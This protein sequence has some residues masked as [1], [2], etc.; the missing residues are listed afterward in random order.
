MPI[1]IDV[2]NRGRIELPDGT[3]EA[4]IDSI[5]A[6]EF[7]PTGEDIAQ[8]L[9]EDPTFR[10]NDQQFAEFEKYSKTKQ[11]D[12]INGIASGIDSLV[13]TAATAASQGVQGAA[14]NPINYLEGIGQGTRQLYGFL[15]QSQDLG[16]ALFQFKDLVSGTGTLQSR[17]E[18]FNQ[19]RDFNEQSLKYESG[20]ETMLPKEMV[21]PEFAQGVALIA[22]PTMLVP[23][24]GQALG[25]EKLAARA[26]GRGAEIAGRGVQAAARPFVR[27]GQAAEG[28]VTQATGLT[29]EAIRSAAATSGVL[30]ATG[31]APAA[32]G[33]GALPT[34]ARTAVDVGTALE[35]A[36]SQ[37]GRA[38]TRIGALEAVGKIPEA[39][40]RQR[41][42]GT[43]G[44][45][46]GDAALNAA[47]VGTTGSIEG[48]TV[49]GVLGYLS[50]GEEG[51][52]AGIGSGAAS[53][54]LGSL[55]ARGLQKLTGQQARAA[56]KEDF[57]RYVAA[58][59]EKTAGL[60][61]DLEAR[62][63][64]DVA[65]SFMDATGVVRGVLGDV[66]VNL[67][68]SEDFRKKFGVGSR[69]VQISEAETPSVYINA[70]IYGKGRGDNPL[71]TLGHEMFHAFESSQQLADK[72]S[73]IKD[74]L[75]GSYVTKDG[76][77]TKVTNGMFDDAEID[78]RFNEYRD[79][80][81]P[82]RAASL[83]AYDTTEK[84]GRFIA[85]E[86]AGE[87]MG[88]LLAGQK[89][90]AMLRGFKGVTRS[91]LDSVLMKNADSTLNTI[92]QKLER[93]FG[94]KPVDSVLYPDI[95]KASPQL[96]AMLRDLVR[97]RG[98]LDER[99][100]AG[101]NDVTRAV[102]PG[103]M[104]NPIAAK[105]AEDFG[106]AETENG[107]T[108]WLSDEVINLRNNRD[109]TAI[110]DILLTR[111]GAR[112]I[113]GAI[114]GRLSPE[115]LSA[116]EQSQQVSSRAKN[117]IRA[118]ASAIENG[119][120]IFIDYNAATRRVLNKLTGK[121][122]SKYS[123]GIRLSQ[124]EV[125]PYAFYFSQ[126]DNPVIKAIDIT[127]MRRALERMTASD[128]TVSGQ[129]QN[130]D[131][132]M[133]DF[134]RY[135]T[136]LDSGMREPSAKLFGEE[137]AK[138]LADVFNQMEMDGRK[139]IRDFRLDR[140]GSVDPRNFRAKVSEEAI[141]FS[142]LRWMPDETVGDARVINSEEGYRI[143]AKDK[144][145]LYGPDG[146]LI[147]IYDKQQQAERKADATETRIQ[148]EV[149]QLEYQARNESRQT[150]E[151]GGGNRPER[152][153]QGGEEGGQ[154]LGQIRQE[155]DVNKTD[156]LAIL[157]GNLQLNLPKRPTVM[158]IATAL[159]DRFGTQIDWKSSTPEQNKKLRDS[160]VQEAVRAVGLHPEAK[161]WYDENVKL[162]MD[163]MRELDPD[164]AKPENDFI[165]KAILAATSD[166][167]KVGPQFEQTW[168]EYSNWK[169]TGEI[170]G[171]FVSGDRIENIQTNLS[172][173]N[174][175]V[176]SVGW[177]ATKD[178]FTRKGTVKEVRKAL[179][180]VFGWTKK[181]AQG[182]GSSELSDE[183][184]P[185]AVVLGPK[186]GS[187]FNNL[188]GDFSSVTMDRWFMR[189]MGRLTGTHVDTSAFQKIGS[190]RN[191]LRESIN[192]LTP[193]EKEFLKISSDKIEGD[194]IDAAA[195]SIWTRFSKKE[196]RD[197]AAQ[198]LSDGRPF[199]EE[200]RKRSNAL[201]KIQSP[202]VEAPVNGRHRRWIRQRIAEVQSEL[203][204]KGIELENA[205]LQ[206][207]LWYLEKE[208][209]DKL[210]YRAK[211]GDSDY[212][213]AAASLYERVVG[214]P[215]ELYAAGTGRIRA[216][217]STGRSEVVGPADAGQPAAAPAQTAAT[218]ED[219][220][221][222]VPLGRFGIDPATRGTDFSDAIK[223]TK[224]EHQ[225][226]F[227][228]DDK[229][230]EFYSSPST[231][232]FLSDD[233]LAGVAVT[234]YGDLVSV[235]KHPASKADIKP[236]LAE[237]AERSQTL[238]AFDVNGF[239]PN[240]YSKFG[241]RPAARVPFNREF[242]PAGWRYDL[243]GEPDVVLMVRDVAGVSGLPD[244]TNKTYADVKAD[245][246]SVGYDEAV[247]IQQEAK[248]KVASSDQPRYMPQPDPSIPGAYSV[249]GGFRILPGKTGGRLRVYGPSGALVG[250]AGSMD[251]AQRMIRRKNRF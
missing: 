142:K 129:W 227:A 150:A 211:P 77:V 35:A 136:N 118:V 111:P 11:T 47:L 157:D 204:S 94:T 167:N 174:Q 101:D 59:D 180:D 108:R 122:Q 237:A 134:A 225:F 10:L 40:L 179:V 69:G 217:G 61:L 168:K 86:I 246:P 98:K 60:L 23:G 43:I 126:A 79:K 238:D 81:T 186:L 109:N 219:T 51:A 232:L 154:A 188:Y 71:Y 164:I 28:F 196:T 127:K 146:K 32:A 228:V 29:P 214:R 207:V 124:R 12:W 140:M 171:K 115:Q 151:A 165:F 14:L 231:Q 123:S 38:P 16:S 48:A 147:G 210:N 155:G 5:V 49:G 37:L 34:I 138:I 82:E 148:P 240:L 185:F 55:G 113:D 249:T 242:A 162:T 218:P 85:S 44:Q 222:R 54:A 247:R 92:A 100:L 4:E 125:L 53:G 39:N 80:L 208:L 197:R 198:L 33:V 66:G 243:A 99:I 199:M 13:Q 244:M 84:R 250:I 213:S 15:A 215:S 131:G 67:L 190:L 192:N 19:A 73:E 1:V 229:G 212:A 58:Q 181:E 72:A 57:D 182:I 175:M 128:G 239:L 117:K 22:D 103:D 220:G 74:A 9:A 170:S 236:L 166:G 78:R 245:V 216:I 226:G 206:A 176:K 24:F 152:G 114:Y 104:G 8:R 18:Q 120:S 89:P 135:L 153:P 156:G 97:A 184:V 88:A 163:V 202:L 183:V 68:S 234:D 160:V 110:Q 105:I 248:A 119:N 87:Y 7:P 30:A 91:L 112:L 158:E 56:R 70:E 21:N 173:I 42:I 31:I 195:K 139:F 149:S 2:P 17:R 64:L 36:G 106:L 107:V 45:Y 145:R 6:K 143:V 95:R 93:T 133:S 52:A 161:G 203:K 137:K 41:I 223:R 102:R 189:T 193:S 20:Q 75:V 132:F 144:Y 172:M 194:K 96:N 233:G 205:D 27:F 159:Q 3:P 90:D 141:Q 76:V 62:H 251:E 83:A 187:F 25:V 235:F 46:G 26:V 65:S 209:Y 241:F 116:I 201:K 50:G 169:N 191:A 177:E 63:G 178:F 230:S 224:A 221:R 130:I 200:V 121:Y